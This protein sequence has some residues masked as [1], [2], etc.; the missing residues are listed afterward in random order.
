MVD[1]QGMYVHVYIRTYTYMIIDE[2][3]YF[4]NSC[5]CHDN[6][7]GMYMSSMC[8]PNICKSAVN[9]FP[10]VSLVYKSRT[11]YI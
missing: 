1:V 8:D 2:L 6:S 5:N 3:Q 9:K 4:D 7:I 11:N 10:Y